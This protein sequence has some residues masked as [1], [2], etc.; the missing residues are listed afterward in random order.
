MILA[1]CKTTFMTITIQETKKISGCWMFHDRNHDVTVFVDP[2]ISGIVCKLTNF[3]WNIC[4]MI[5]TS[6]SVIG[7]RT[8]KCLAWWHRYRFLQLQ[9]CTQLLSFVFLFY[10]KSS[11]K[12]KAVV[13]LLEEL[14]MYSDVTAAV[15]CS[16]IP[17]LLS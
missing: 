15:I 2:L 5:L 1:Q 13:L 17:L 11:I 7:S 10:W 4:K 14:L 8:S 9:A 6:L 12:D 16:L 3:S